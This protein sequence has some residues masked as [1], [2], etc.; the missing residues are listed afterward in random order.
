VH[1]L[2]QGA[3]KVIVKPP[4]SAK[5]R[6]DLRNIREL[7]PDLLRDGNPSRRQRARRRRSPVRCAAACPQW[8]EQTVKPVIEQALVASALQS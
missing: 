1:I 3:Y 7:V 8:I 4:F 2:V 6:F 5:H